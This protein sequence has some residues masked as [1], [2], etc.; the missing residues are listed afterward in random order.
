MYFQEEEKEDKVMRIFL[1]M[2]VSFF[3]CLETAF[4][5]VQEGVDEL[6]RRSEDVRLEMERLRDLVTGRQQ[7]QIPP[8][9]PDEEVD[10]PAPTPTQRPSLPARE[11]GEVTVN[12]LERRISR[13]EDEVNIMFIALTNYQAMFSASSDIMRGTQRN[14]ER[15]RLWIQILAGCVGIV[16]GSLGFREWLKRKKELKP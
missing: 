10:A 1:V 11:G 8:D 4:S 12:A 2:V 7:D 16:T 14:Q 13:L 3:I 6:R 9:S 5:Q 15:L